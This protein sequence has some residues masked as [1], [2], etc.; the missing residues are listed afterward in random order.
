MGETRFTPG[1]WRREQDT[2][3]VWGECNADDMSTF[4]MGFPVAAAQ[5]TGDRRWGRHLGEDEQAANAT[6]IAAAPELYAALE[7]IAAH[8]ERIGDSRKDAPFI[9]AANA[10]LAKARGE[11]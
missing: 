7:A 6:L 5:G 4:G 1:P 11:A 9:D 8:L 3:L 10:A 2:T